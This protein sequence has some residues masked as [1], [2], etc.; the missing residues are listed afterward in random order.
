MKS[1]PRF[2]LFFAF[3]AGLAAIVIYLLVSEPD[4]KKSVVATLRPAATQ[5]PKSES[6][7]RSY[8]APSAQK[9]APASNGPIPS[10]PS[11]QPG[12]VL[13]PTTPPPPQT[14]P[15]E[16]KP[17]SVASASGGA[18]AGGSTSLPPETLATR[19][20][21]MAHV[22]LRAPEEANPDSETNRRVLNTMVMKALAQS[23]APAP[24][25]TF[26]K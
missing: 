25:S 2:Y 15:E 12:T 18:P 6:V 9:A 17:V 7:D 16:E 14:T 24:S 8:S 11:Q 13:P 19:R 26:S 5:T 22:S 23:R 10:A 3:G 4:N 20:M 21:Y 1:R